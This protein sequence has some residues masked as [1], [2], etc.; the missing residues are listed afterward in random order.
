[1]QTLKTLA[2][3]AGPCNRARRALVAGRPPRAGRSLTGRGGRRP[4][5]DGL[6]GP[7]QSSE[8]PFVPGGMRR[9]PAEPKST[10]T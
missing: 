8:N 4:S 3:V 5:R 6:L 7:G 10:T 9:S 2:A 1:M